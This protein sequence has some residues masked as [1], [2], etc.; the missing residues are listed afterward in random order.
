MSAYLKLL[1][2]I[3]PAHRIGATEDRGDVVYLEV[4]GVLGSD[5]L[6]CGS[7]IQVEKDYPERWS[8]VEAIGG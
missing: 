6:A 8:F 7:A 2:P 1:A 5:V 3:K 4:D